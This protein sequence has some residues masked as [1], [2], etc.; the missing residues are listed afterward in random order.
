MAYECLVGLQVTNDEVYTQ[1]REAMKPILENFGGG[2]RY[3]FKVSEVLKPEEAKS[4]NRVF[5]IYFE[6]EAAMNSF[7][8]NTEY[9]K[10][11]EKFFEESVAETVIISSY[12]N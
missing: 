5:V 8:S 12:N 1:Y 7:F 11:K 6:D 9:L 4:L 2:F 3:D 10:V